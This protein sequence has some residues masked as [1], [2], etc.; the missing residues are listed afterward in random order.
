MP[1]PI[2][3]LVCD[4]HPIVR[5]AVRARLAEIPGIEIAGEASDGR[6][7]VSLAR[8]LKPEV[9]LLDVEMPELDGISATR[10]IVNLHPGTGV[11]LFTAHDEPDMIKLASESGASGYLLKSSEQSELGEAIRSVAAGATWFPDSPRPAGDNDE[12]VRLRTLTARERQILD[13][14]ARGHRADG[15]AGELGISPATVYTHVRNTV[16]KLGVDTRSQAVAI[17]VRY[18]FITPEK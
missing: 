18:S 5:E 3:V 4:D 16:A 7:A 12:L 14:L 6:E 2:R 13:L 8:K 11:I 10:Q 17:A 15:V 1:S 9:V